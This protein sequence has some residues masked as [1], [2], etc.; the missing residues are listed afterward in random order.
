MSKNGLLNLGRGSAK[1]I[2]F[3]SVMLFINGVAYIVVIRLI[4]AFIGLLSTEA[5]EYFSLL[6]KFLFLLTAVMFVKAVA[7]KL[8]SSFSYR[9]TA[10]VKYN[11]RER[12]FNK[13]KRL[14]PA[15]V[16]SSGTAELIANALDGVE[17]LE[18]LFGRFMPQLIYSLIIPSVLFFVTFGIYPAFA[19]VMLS[20]V[21]I[22]PLSMMLIS[23]W[24]KRSM[25]GFWNDY[26]GLSSL[27]LEN[28]QGIVTLK[29]FNKSEK[30]MKEMESKAWG[31]RNSTMELL[32]MQ[33]ASISVMDTLVY[34]FAGAGIFLAVYG[35][36]VGIV[37]LQ[38]FFI[39]LMLSVEFFLPIRKLGS[40]FHAGVNGIQAGRKVAA[41]L[42]TQ[43]P[44]R[45]PMSAKLPEGS[46]IVFENVSFYYD[47][48]LPAV[49]TDT[50]CR[51]PSGGIY[52]I[53]G[54]SGCGK[55]TLGR[56][57][58]GFFDPVSGS[59][60]FGGVPV[61]D[62]PLEQLRRR[63]TLVEARSRIF[64]GTIEDNLKLAVPDADDNRMLSACR[65]AGLCG[66]GKARGLVADSGDLRK[67]TGESGS[68]LSGGERQRL[69][70]A[71]AV[72]L[73]PDVFVFDEAAGS[74]DSESEEIIRDTIYN[75]PAS[76]TVFI[77]SHR[78]S[79][80]HGADRLLTID[81]GKIVECGR[82]L[83]AAGEYK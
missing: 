50:S 41:F 67:E 62:I 11:I 16:D 54:A 56:L 20:A 18:I 78:R 33:L 47:T 28:L 74:V 19:L 46:D 7:S 38:E 52:G 24:A 31:F 55:S 5:V 77:I 37:S 1:W 79:M 25:K 66:T 75:L 81:D 29:L 76:K 9:I 59:I 35:F 44:L 39:L 83:T 43:E 73:N 30:R 2:C 57:L 15:W 4:A 51:F 34:G 27:F 26:Q 68:K 6:P 22:I 45:V 63:I 8:E 71:R 14:G 32:R 60:S 58:L 49:L 40:L 48:A 61:T 23:K 69:A 65:A 12:I 80:L 70:I 72:L 82:S 21:P 36:H 3:S 53:A 17:A 10:K 64:N 42:N 13:I